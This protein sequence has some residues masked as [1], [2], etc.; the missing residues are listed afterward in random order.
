MNQRMPVEALTT[1][2]VQGMP[3]KTRTFLLI[4]FIGPAVYFGYQGDYILAALVAGACLSAFS[5]FRIGATAM[6]ASV[7]AITTAVTYAPSIAYQHE[8]RFTEWFGTTGLLN[9]FVSIGAV[10]LGITIFASLLVMLVTR[11][12][13]RFR[14]R[15]DRANRWIGFWIGGVE[16]VAITV[17]ILGGALVLEPIEKDR[18]RHNVNQTERGKQISFCVLKTAEH[19]HDSEVGSYIEKYNPFVQF[20]ELNKIEEVQKSVQVLS[21]P[22]KI[23][24]LINHPD[25]RRLQSRPEVQTAVKRVTEDPEIREALNAGGPMNRKI[26]MTLMNHPAILELIDQPGF[27][28]AATKVILGSNLLRP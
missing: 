6:I 14:P 28:E 20:P 3:L 21:D 26:A 18:A 2:C 8:F 4:S 12:I 24:S 7:V 22:K 27:M 11:G 17:F 10:G 13:Y 25:V 1:Q 19:V 15:L 23:Q 9:R 5:G 16:G